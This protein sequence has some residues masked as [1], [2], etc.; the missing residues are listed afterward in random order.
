VPAI[1]TN[2]R[3]VIEILHEMVVPPAGRRHAWPFDDER[4]LEAVLV[5]PALVVPAPVAEVETPIG[6]VD[7]DRVFRE[8]ELGQRAHQGGRRFH[9]LSAGEA[10]LATA[11]DVIHAA[12]DFRTPRRTQLGIAHAVLREHQPVNQLGDYVIGPLLRLFHD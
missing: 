7:Y 5:H 8:P 3:G 11:A 4:H 12:A 1:S 9:P 2:R 6:G 10:G